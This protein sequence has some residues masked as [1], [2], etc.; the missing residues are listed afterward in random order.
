MA[1]KMHAVDG[2]LGMSGSGNRGNQK[3][4]MRKL[5]KG[6]SIP[7]EEAACCL[8]RASGLIQ[9]NLITWKCYIVS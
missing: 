1:E 3:N 5:H 7:T 2:R 8:I 4:G 6:V 9:R